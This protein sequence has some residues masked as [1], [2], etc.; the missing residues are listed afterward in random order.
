MLKVLDRLVQKGLLQPITY[1]RAPNPNSLSYDPNSY[2][3]F[4]QAIRHHTNTCIY[5]K[6]EI[7]DLIDARKITDPK[8]PSIKNNPFP[9]YNTLMINLGI[10][11]EKVLN[12]FKDLSEK[13]IEKSP[14]ALEDAKKVNK[15]TTLSYL[16]RRIEEEVIEEM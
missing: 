1:F 14:D 7:Q 11:E 4:H 5:L 12:S 8:N 10:N 13:P 16:Q 6:H 2:C 3:N 9:N 15:S